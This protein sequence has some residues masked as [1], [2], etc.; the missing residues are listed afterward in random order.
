[1]TYGK[2]LRKLNK[3]CGENCGNLR[4]N[5]RHRGLIKTCNNHYQYG[6]KKKQ[7]K[8]P[9]KSKRNQEKK[10]NNALYTVE[11]AQRRPAGLSLQRDG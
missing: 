4:A 5:N 7:L 1:M 11:H 9:N 6:F 8:Q 3:E 10:A 2:K